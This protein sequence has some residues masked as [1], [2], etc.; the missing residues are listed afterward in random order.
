VRRPGA[1]IRDECE[2]DHTAVRRV[3]RQ[4][5]GEP[6]GAVVAD[7]VDDLRLSLRSEG[8]LSLVAT[9]EDDGHDGAAPVVG[10]VMFTRNLLDAPTT[11]VDVHVLSPLGVLPQYRRRGIGAALIGEG[12]RTLAER[13]VPAVFLEGDPAYYRRHGFVPAGDLGFRRPSL[14]IPDAAFQVRL[15]PAYEAWMTG[16]LVYRREFWDHDAVGLRE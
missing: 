12:V 2:G 16:T 3:H 15:L 6:E 14:R 13:G 4:A 5:F 11:L 7:L 10:H 1:G 9:D 8:G